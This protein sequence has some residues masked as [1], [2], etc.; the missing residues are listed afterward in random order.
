MQ[1]NLKA[2]T[3]ICTSYTWVWI[4]KYTRQEISFVLIS[5]TSRENVEEIRSGL[6][7]TSRLLRH[8]RWILCVKSVH[9]RLI[10]HAYISDVHLDLETRLSRFTGTEEVIVYSYSFATIA[11]AIPAYA[12]RTDIIYWLV[13]TAR[14]VVVSVEV[15]GVGGEKGSCECRGGWSRRWEV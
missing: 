5:G 11:S 9:F 14:R 7:W 8:Y 1:L 10:F 3:F 6:M 2:L 13:R 15:V 4:A 12:K